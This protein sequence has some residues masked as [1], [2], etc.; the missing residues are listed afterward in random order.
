MGEFWGEIT[1][2]KRIMV[3]PLLLHV[4]WWNT[5]NNRKSR[6]YDATKAP[7]GSQASAFDSALWTFLLR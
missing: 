1:R 3:R 6:E 2:P 5:I 4:R 7:S